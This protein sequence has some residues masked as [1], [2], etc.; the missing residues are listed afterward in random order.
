MSTP[1]VLPAGD[2]SVAAWLAPYSGGV[3]GAPRG[4]CT[5]QATLPP[6]GD[7]ALNA[8]FP[9]SQ[10]CTFGSAPSPSPGP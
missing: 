7:V 3:A 2:Y 10:A 5:T 1:L 4:E 8:D 6:L 9:A